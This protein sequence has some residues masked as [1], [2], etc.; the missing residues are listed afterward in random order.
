M[1]ILE[2]THI[3]RDLLH[4]EKTCDTSKGVRFYATIKTQRLS[5]SKVRIIDPSFGTL[6]LRK[7]SNLTFGGY[8]AGTTPVSSVRSFLFVV[9]VLLRACK[10]VWLIDDFLASSKI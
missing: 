10:A 6:K 4:K 5:K 1:R 8:L 7:D 9:Q 3:N 2:Y